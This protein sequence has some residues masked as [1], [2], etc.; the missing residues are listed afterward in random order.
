MRISRATSVVRALPGRPTPTLEEVVTA[1]D[2][3]LA[4]VA[5]GNEILLQRTYGLD[6]LAPLYAEALR[7]IRQAPGRIHAI[8][9]LT[10]Y[11]RED[12]RIVDAGL[13]CLNDRSRLV[14]KEACGILAYSLRRDLIPHLQP[15]LKHRDPKTRAHAAAAIDA[16][17]HQNHHYFLDTEHTG[18]VFWHPD[19]DEYFA[20]SARRSASRE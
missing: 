2:Q 10:R 20:D 4:S 18:T 6:A 19:P 12:P 7:H 16:I 9:W 1:L 14:R 3:R 13:H 17:E 15:L 5:G 8:Y 11:A